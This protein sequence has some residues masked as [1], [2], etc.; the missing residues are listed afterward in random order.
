[1]GILLSIFVTHGRLKTSLCVKCRK[2]D[3]LAKGGWLK[4][5]WVATCKVK[6][7]LVRQQLWQ[8]GKCKYRMTKSIFKEQ[9]GMGRNAAI[10][11]IVYERLF[12]SLRHGLWNNKNFSQKEQNWNSL[13][14]AR[15]LWVWRVF[16]R[17]WSLQELELTWACSWNG[18]NWPKWKVSWAVQGCWGKVYIIASVLN[19]LD[20]NAVDTFDGKV[21]TWRKWTLYKPVCK[22]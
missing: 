4:L 21:N 19:C 5:L 12:R 20:W 13:K 8:K 7:V 11:G 18:R 6:I 17:S 22:H 14:S 16:V 10:S 1:M 9:W 2:R 3:I 15:F